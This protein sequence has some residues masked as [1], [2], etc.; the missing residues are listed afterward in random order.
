M[1]NKLPQRKHVR[2]K[3]HNYNVTGSYFVT[4]CTSDRKNT[5][6]DIVGA[7]HESPDIKLKPYGKIIKGIIENL[8]DNLYVIVDRYVI[9]PNHVHLVFVITRE[10]AERAIRE[11]PLRYKSIISNAVSY[12]KMN[13][14]KQI[15]QAFD[16]TEKIWQRSFYEHIIRDK[17]DYDS[18]VKY[19]TENPIKWFYDDPNT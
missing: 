17:D 14:T 19:I 1:E 10:N 7:I 8:P 18:I 3:Q 4:I 9:M 15:H 16:N 2:L 6:C 13:A 12:I 5:L 11:S